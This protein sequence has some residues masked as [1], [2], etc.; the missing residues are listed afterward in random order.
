MREYFT[1]KQDCDA[2]NLAGIAMGGTEFYSDCD[3]IFND[4]QTD[5]EHEDV[6]RF[7]LTLIDGVYVAEGVYVADSYKQALLVLFEH[8]IA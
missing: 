8:I 2:Y 7:N 5:D 1:F 6:A 4:A 3:S